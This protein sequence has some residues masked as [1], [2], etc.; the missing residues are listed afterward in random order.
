MR[1]NY[2]KTVQWEVSK[3]FHMYEGGENLYVNL[4]GAVN[5]F[6]ITEHFNS[7]QHLSTHNTHNTNFID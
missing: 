4:R 1:Q 7:Y 3:G 5:I 6:T 2:G